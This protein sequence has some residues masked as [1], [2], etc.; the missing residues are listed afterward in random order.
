MM[1]LLRCES[2]DR[3]RGNACVISNRAFFLLDEIEKEER[4]KL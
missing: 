2:T 4:E 1:E 3:K